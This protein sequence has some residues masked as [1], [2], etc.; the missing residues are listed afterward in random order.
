MVVFPAI[1][2]KNRHV[3]RLLQGKFDKVTEYGAD[4]VDMAKHWVSQGAEWL[5]IVDLDGAK[6]GSPKNTDIIL[7]IASCVEVSIQVGG[8][9]RKKDDIL[10]LIEGG[11]KRV[12]LGTGAISSRDFLEE[13]VNTWQ[14]RVCVSLDCSEGI[15]LGEGWVSNTG[16]KVSDFVRELADIGVGSIVYTDVTRDGMLTGPNFKGIEELLKTTDIPVI[17]SG[18]VSILED[19]LRIAA[20]ENDGII[21]VIIGKAIYEGKIDLKR[22]IDIV[23]EM[24]REGYVNKADNTVS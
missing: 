16:I 2:I 20:M 12:I 1:D 8:G 3:V 7:K 24:K 21:G 4:P 22:A 15:L 9:I 17:A 19:I 10:R 23:S 6:E 11:V 13:A 5:H 14:D 18:G